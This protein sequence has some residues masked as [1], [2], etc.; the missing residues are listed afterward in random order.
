M[1][2]LDKTEEVLDI[3]PLPIILESILLNERE[4][5]LLDRKGQI[6]GIRFL[7]EMPILGITVGLYTGVIVSEISFEPIGKNEY[8]EVI[9][10]GGFIGEDDI[11]LKK[12]CDTIIGTVN[13][14]C[15]ILSELK[16]QNYT[17][18]VNNNKDLST[19]KMPEEYDWNT[20]PITQ[21]RNLGDSGYEMHISLSIKRGN[22]KS[23]HWRRGH[24]RKIV[25][26]NGISERIWIEQT[27][28]REDKLNEEGLK[29]S[30]T[31]IKEKE[32]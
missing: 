21:I 19:P 24:W 18:E 27:L 2:V 9:Y 26:N 5:S 25:H 30:A 16:P 3:L 14:F 8:Q 28:I 6:S 17:L 32:A 29:G 22:E 7:E 12:F 13:G 20:V 15:K 1:V 11:E 4:K 10:D 23:P 31:L